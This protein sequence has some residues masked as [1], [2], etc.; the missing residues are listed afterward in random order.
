MTDHAKDHYEKRLEDYDDVF[1][2]IFNVIVFR[3]ENRIL[4]SDLRA[5]M[6]RSGYQVDGKFVEQERDILKYWESNSMKLVVMGIENQTKEDS[7]LVARCISYDGANYRDQLR[8]RAGI[9]RKN[10]R[11]REEGKRGTGAGFLN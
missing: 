11:R 6:T 1:A 7:E 4:D 2:D 5:G 9:R 3:G 10:S 8:K